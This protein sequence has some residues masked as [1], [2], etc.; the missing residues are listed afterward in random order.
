M[1]VPT[2]PTDNLYKF[3]AIV[4]LL[5][6]A[7]AI[8]IPQYY[9]LERFKAEIRYDAT[10]SDRHDR[11]KVLQD[12]A[13]FIVEQK[14]KAGA[15]LTATQNR[16]DTAR[17]PQERESARTTNLRAYEEFQALDAQFYKRIEQV[18][19]LLKEEAQQAEQRFIVFFTRT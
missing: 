18:Q 11:V 5:M 14:K 2:I 6:I 3:M 1:D 16:M 9:M 19:D 8:L 4:G 15:E 13:A 12:G 10:T 17:T 7:A